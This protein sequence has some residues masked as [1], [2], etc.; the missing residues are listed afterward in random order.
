MSNDYAGFFRGLADKIDSG[1]V[2]IDGMEATFDTM[3]PTSSL[4]GWLFPKSTGGIKL[5]VEYH[6]KSRC[7]VTV[8]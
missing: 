4:G 1:E 5:V 6:D 7:G 8:N 2:R 3:C